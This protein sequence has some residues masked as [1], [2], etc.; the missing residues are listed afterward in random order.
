MLHWQYSTQL[1]M[2]VNTSPKSLPKVAVCILNYNGHQANYLQQFLPTVYASEYAN[3]DIYVIDNKS[4][5]D[6]VAYLQK[7]GFVAL[8]TPTENNRF[9][10]ALDQNYWFAGGYNHGLKDIDADY[11]VLLNS[12]VAVSPNWITPIIELMEKD[13]QIAACQ[14]KIKLFANPVLF[15]HAGGSGGF[16]DKWGYPFCRGRIFNSLETDTGQYENTQ[17]IFWASGAAFFIRAKL[18][19]DIGGL[20]AD[21]KAHMEEIDLCWRLQRANYKIMVCPQSVV[22][23]VGG[24]TLPK[25]NPHKTYLNFKNSLT[26]IFKNETGLKMYWIIWVRLVLDGVA[27]TRFLTKGEFGNI[28]AVIKA[29]WSFFF[30]FF[31]NLKKQKETTQQIAAAQF[32]SK[33]Q[34]V[35]PQ[36]YAKSIVWQH[37]VKG[38]QKYSEL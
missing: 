31:N 11:F 1:P 15:E 19:Y 10:I 9:L 28:G 37:F 4:T 38:K 24:G 23:H 5:D 7:E 22:H 26:T 13:Q 8:N 14:P 3:L 12:D 29:H 35:T 34:V 18:Y 21:Y 32:P 17:P 25:E 30:S 27:A 20:D 6:S 33:K 2:N 16:V 36:K